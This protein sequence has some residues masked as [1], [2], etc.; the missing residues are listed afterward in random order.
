MLTLTVV[1][2]MHQGMNNTSNKRRR[3]SSPTSLIN[4]YHLPDTI[5]AD[6]VATYLPK[7]SRAIFAVAM[8]APLSSWAN[9]INHSSISI[10]STA[11]LAASPSKN[12]RQLQEY[13]VHGENGD[14]WAI[15]DFE[16]IEKS[17]ASKLSDDDLSAILICTNAVNR[18]RRL[19]LTGLVNITG[20]GLSPLSGSVV[21]QQIDLSLL[22]L[23]EKPSTPHIALIF[24]DQVF[25]ILHSIIGKEGNSLKHLLFPMKWIG[26]HVRSNQLVQLQRDFNHLLMSRPFN[27]AECDNHE[28]CVESEGGDM[29][30]MYGQPNTCY[31]CLENICDS[32]DNDRTIPILVACQQCDKYHC[33]RCVPNDECDDCNDYFCKA[34]VTSTKCD[35][36][37]GNFCEGCC[38]TCDCCNKS[39]CSGCEDDDDAGNSTILVCNSCSKSNCKTCGDSTNHVRPCSKC[40]NDYCFDCLLKD[41]R[42]SLHNDIAHDCSGCSRKIVSEMLK[43]NNRLKER[44]DHLESLMET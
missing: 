24:E 2:N 16:D 28:S 8:S 33:E 1:S 9:A 34:C 22:K 23:R 6:N 40:D 26:S 13:G 20:R 39:Q 15:L 11:I 32:G 5:L 17:L 4:I 43:E 25:P 19:K 3:D 36:C 12:E 35:D 14:M 7:P 31:S 18:L 10:T 29:F 30:S 42:S 27:C 41:Y 38:N 21:L 44:V 37:N